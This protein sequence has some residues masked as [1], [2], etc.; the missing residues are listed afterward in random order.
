MQSSSALV[1]CSWPSNR[2]EISDPF[3]C[4]VSHLAIAWTAPIGSGVLTGTVTRF[5]MSKIFH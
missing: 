4:A 5:S 2:H 3:L 1:R